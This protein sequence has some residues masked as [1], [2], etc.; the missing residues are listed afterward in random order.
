MWN[1]TRSP[2]FAVIFGRL[3]NIMPETKHAH[4]HAL[5]TCACNCSLT[6][7]VAR[8]TI[9]QSNS[10]ENMRSDWQFPLYECVILRSHTVDGIEEV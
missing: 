8:H 5:S 10:M 9:S 7:H 4:L 6:V 3:Q 1:R 2:C